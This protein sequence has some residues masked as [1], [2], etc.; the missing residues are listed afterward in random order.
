LDRSEFLLQGV[1]VD[2]LSGL[3]IGP[4]D[5]PLV[6][7]E[8]QRE[9]FYADH[10]SRTVLQ[11]KSSNDPNVS[12]E[13]IP[14]ID[15]IISPLPLTLGRK[16]DYIVASHVGEHVPDLLGWLKALL[17]WLNPDGI[18]ILALPDKRYTFDCYRELST[19]GQLIEAFLQQRR[20]P[21]ISSVYDAFSR[22]VRADAWALWEGVP[23]PQPFENIYSPELALQLAIETHEKDDYRD[24]HCW[25]LTVDSFRQMLEELRKLDLLDFEWVRLIHPQ[26]YQ[27]EFIVSLRPGSKV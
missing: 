22:S 16:F 24:V 23:P 6:K 3:E 13:D 10:A 1:D 17:M 18:L 11:N 27:L 25:V 26:K 5:R 14:D 7:R 4:L 19:V 12:V 2:K 21:S 9:I 20:R 8:G 15:Y